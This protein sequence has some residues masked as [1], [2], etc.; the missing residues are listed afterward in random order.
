MI[1]RARNGWNLQQQSTTSKGQRNNRRYSFGV[2]TQAKST[3]GAALHFEPASMP[4]SVSAYHT[5]P[6][7][8]APGSAGAAA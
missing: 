2:R 8:D 7:P 4:S 1:C 5:G 3:S 6:N